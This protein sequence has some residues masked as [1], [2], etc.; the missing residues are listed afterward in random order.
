MSDIKNENS[1][2]ECMREIPDPRAPYNQ[3]HK[4]LDIIIIAVTAILCG[5][6]TWNEIEDWAY[7]KREWLGPCG[8]CMGFRSVPC[9]W[10]ATGK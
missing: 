7:S 5:M 4:F 6:D 10:A 1:L 3:K 9:T 8:K 2:I